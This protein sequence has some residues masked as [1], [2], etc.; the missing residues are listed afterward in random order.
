MKFLAPIQYHIRSVL[1]FILWAS[2]KVSQNLIACCQCVTT[3]ILG[4]TSSNNRR[5]NEMFSYVSRERSS[6][7]TFY[8]RISFSTSHSFINL[9][10][11]VFWISGGRYTP[12]LTM[13]M[14]YPP[15]LQICSPRTRR[16]SVI[17]PSRLSNWATSQLGMNKYRTT[18]SFGYC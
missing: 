10:D 3:M 9:P 6:V 15:D 11:G 13:I 12:P 17:V 8:S 5:L 16:F 4:S 18:S 7:I 1:T 14:S 2:L